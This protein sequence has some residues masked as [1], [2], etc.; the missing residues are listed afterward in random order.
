MKA[1]GDI[2]LLK[3]DRDS[4]SE[5]R[6]FYFNSLP[7]FQELHLELLVEES[8]CLV[9]TLDRN[10]IGYFIKTKDNI[11]VEF[12]LTDD[13]ISEGP[14]LFL[15]II[16]KYSIRSVYCKTFD[17][18][19]L[20]CCLMYST[21]YK[22]IGTLFRSF[23]DT[24][25]YKIDGLTHRIAGEPDYPFLLQ[26]EDGLYE[27]PE[28]LERFVKGGNITM[29]LKDNELY[30][31][32]Y[33]I[34]VHEDWDFY[35]IGMWVNPKFRHR[36]IATGII[37]YLKETCLKHHW[38][39]VAGC[40]Y[41][42]TASQ[43]TLEKNGFTSKYKLLEFSFRMEPNMVN[44]SE[45]KLVGNRLTMTLAENKT[46]DLWR[47]FMPRRR[48]ITNRVN[49][50]LISMQVYGEPM[51]PGD[52]NQEF[53]KWAAV[54]VTDFE[55]IP[56]GMETFILSGGLY[57]VFP[58]KGLSTDNSLF[59]HIFTVWLPGSGYVLDHRPHFEILGDRYK[60]GDSDSEED[61]WIPVKI[62]GFEK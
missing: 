10:A 38:N 39:P 26:Q 53:D 49:K 45:K 15:D 7:E 13:Y 24:E 34:R 16:R 8:D 27:T 12:Y 43:R 33:L 1:P 36:G 60:N 5:L 57:A 40:A 9:I 42:N 59:V 6:T 23:N 35:D 61:I 17:S 18:L 41:E 31:C 48:E 47:A 55:N 4:L 52:L 20:N 50:E 32:A 56:E 28:E 3:T 46:A 22:I 62:A 54:E 58:Y 19:L 44:L 30:G 29:F 11:L 2:Q 51:K 37:S 14:S 21:G 25:C